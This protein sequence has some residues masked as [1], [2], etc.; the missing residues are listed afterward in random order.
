MA[1]YVR[2]DWMIKRLLRNKADSVVLEGFLSVLLE[3]QITI[4]NI[5]ESESNQDEDTQK[6]NRVD[7]LVEDENKAKYIIEVQNDHE[8]DF[9][10]RMV[11]GTSKVIAQYTKLGEA[12][13]KIT[14]VY[15]IN[16]VYF[17][18]GQG[19]GYVYKGTTQ[20]TNI[21][22]KNDVLQL[23]PKQHILYNAEAVSDIFPEYYLLRVNNFDE[24]AIS[25]LQQWISVLKTGDIP[26]EFTAQ[27]LS[28][29][30]EAL[31]YNRLT[32]EEKIAY[33]RYLENLTYK[34][35]MLE[36]MDIM[37]HDKAIEKGRAEG[38]HSQAITIAK[39]MKLDSVPIDVISKYTQLSIDEIKSL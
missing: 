16:I 8:I 12:Y 35:S 30:R 6:F 20:F 18:L 14:K 15:S 7:L 3:R 5:L 13:G 32:D 38:A 24:Y 2:F 9:F 28:E 39:Q 25:P 37:A 11:F 31:N 10:Q 1:N 27:G 26:V 19:K 34:Q 22:D 17:G 21:F 29:A 36:T 23:T 4:T 33:R